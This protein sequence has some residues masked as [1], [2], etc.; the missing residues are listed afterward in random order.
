MRVGFLEILAMTDPEEW[1]FVPNG[2]RAPLVTAWWRVSLFARI[3][4]REWHAGRVGPL[5]AWETC[6]IIHPWHEPV[7]VW[8]RVV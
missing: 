8:R 2:T 3:V 6:R 1:A 5:T 7:K 4:G